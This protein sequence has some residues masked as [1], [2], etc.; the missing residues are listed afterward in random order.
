MDVTT[1]AVRETSI[2]HSAMAREIAF[3]PDGRHFASA[4]FDGTA[5][6]WETATARPAGPTI[7]AH[8]LCRDRR[9][10]PRRQHPRC[11]RLRAGRTHQTLGLADGKELRPPLRHDDIILNVSFSPDGRYLAAIKTGDWSKNPEVLVW[12]VASGTVVVRLHHNGPNLR[13]RE[14]VRFRPDGG[15]IATR[16]ADGALHLWELPSGRLLGRRPLDGDGVSRFSPDGRIVAAAANLGVRILD[17][18]TLA[19]LPAGYLRHPDPVRELAFSPDG[20]ILLTAHETGTAQLW[21]VATRKPV[22]PPAVLSGPI[23]A[24]TFTPDG[25]T[26]V[27]VAADGTVRRWPVP[28]PFVE[29]DLD[30]LAE[31]VALLT[32]QRMDDNQGLDSVPGDEWRDPPA[33]ASRRR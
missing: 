11:R 19:P 12:E 5:R 14:S 2:R 24:V 33:G 25:K 7:T 18:A 31:R 3:T 23:R 1:G 10:Q 13:L 16:D 22:G 32:G 28:A 6:V 20:A 4:S 17:G 15:A 8:E 27:C 21:D 26:C 9:V 29:A 30:R